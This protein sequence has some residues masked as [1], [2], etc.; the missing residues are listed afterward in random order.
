MTLTFIDFFTLNVAPAIL[1]KLLG[2]LA[3]IA[4]GRSNEGLA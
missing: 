3:G 2:A 1:I 4:F